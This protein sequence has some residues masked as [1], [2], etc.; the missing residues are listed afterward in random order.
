MKD[1]E[2]LSSD[3]EQ[4]RHSSFEVQ[5]TPLSQASSFDVQQTPLS[6]ASAP[7]SR[8]T[9]EGHGATDDAF[10]NS[11]DPPSPNSHDPPA[12]EPCKGDS[13]K[14]PPFGYP[15]RSQK[16]RRLSRTSGVLH[17]DNH[18]P[19]GGMFM[20]PESVKAMVRQAVEIEEYNVADFYSQD[21]FWAWL[22]TH[23]CFDTLT[24]GVIGLNALW[25]S[26]DTDYNHAALLTKADTIFQVA[27]HSVCGYFTLELLIRFLA[28]EVKRNCLRD[29]WFIFDAIL[30]LMTIGETWVMTGIISLTAASSDG[31]LKNASLLRLIRLLRLLRMARLVRLL[32]AMPEIMI[33]LKGLSMATRSV[34]MTLLLLSV[35]I[36]VFAITFTQLTSGEVPFFLTVPESMNTLLLHGCFGEDL[37][38]VVNTVGGHNPAL[39]A[40]MVCFVLLASLT[41]M[42]MLVGV[43]VE[44]VSVVAAVEK[45]TLQVGFVRTKLHGILR[46][47]DADGDSCISRTE[48]QNILLMPEA[49]RALQE[50]G[51][52]VVGL[53]DFA[54]FIFARDAKISFRDFMDTVLQ[55][56][57]TNT[58]TVKDVVDLRKAIMVELQLIESCI[59]EKT[60]NLVRSAYA[61]LGEKTEMQRG[62]SLKSGS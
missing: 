50:V 62:T 34:L 29:Y 20:D 9:D 21:R 22:A 3:D 4:L 1:R 23:P 39:G 54:D 43:L 44:V 5:Q 33:L 28:F 41:V 18:N 35:I 46:E 37:P 38:D 45:E 27:E 19:K 49:A 53:I 58:A 15:V 40:L 36:Y 55:L 51:V 32:R 12:D 30:V 2:G 59:G 61:S 42:N 52:D 56:R 16:T 7:L 11:H 31:N 48:F 60:E 25:M 10:P 24:L 47:L 6:Q 26:I 17:K 57:G 8:A 13:E 14:K